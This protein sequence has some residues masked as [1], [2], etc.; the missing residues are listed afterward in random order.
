MDMF[1]GG[2]SQ[3]VRMPTESAAARARRER[4]N[5]VSRTERQ[6]AAR[7]NAQS[8]TLDYSSVYSK[9]SLFKSISGRQSR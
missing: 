2:G 4:E 6:K 7:R 3:N 5:R 1:G 8:A 9:P